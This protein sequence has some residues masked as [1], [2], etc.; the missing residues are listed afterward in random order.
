MT[1]NLK[2]QF[3]HSSKFCYCI[4]VRAGFIAGSVLSIIL[5]GALSVL[6]WLEVVHQYSQNMSDKEYAAFV[7]AGVVET[8]LFLVSI[9]GLVGAVARKKLFV[10][11][12]AYFVY[13]HF[14]LNLVFAIYL[15]VAL[16]TSHRTNI[17]NACQDVLVDINS[18][19]KCT[20]LLNTS[21]YVYIAI[22]S[23]ILLLELYGVLVVS[24]Y[25]YQLRQE[26]ETEYPNC[27]GPPPVPPR[28]TRTDRTP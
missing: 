28:H 5:G 21:E 20:K 8:M 11:A 15:F 23:F 22:T 17:V 24:R 14:L 26:R 1:F 9:F 12:Y 7:A 27:A 16:S 4:P 2:E 13:T 19:E 3:F 10:V 6:L 18:Q 25:V